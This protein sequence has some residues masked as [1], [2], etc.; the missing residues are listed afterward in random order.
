M[1]SPEIVYGDERTVGYDYFGY[2]CYVNN[3]SSDS[4]LDGKYVAMSGNGGTGYVKVYWK[5]NTWAQRGSTIN[6]IN[7]EEGMGGAVHINDD[8]TKVIAMAKNY[9]YVFNW[10]GTSDWTLSQS[11]G[12][13]TRSNFNDMS[14]SDDGLTICFGET[15][16]SSSRGLVQVWEYDSVTAQYAQKGTNNSLTGSS[17]LD[18]FGRS[19]DISNDGN[20]IV[21]GADGY[22]G[23]SGAAYVYYWDDNDN[24]WIQLGDT[25]EG[26]YSNKRFGSTVQIGSP[27]N[28]NDSTVIAVS[29]PG[30]DAGFVYIWEYVDNEWKDIVT[31]SKD[32]IHSDIESVLY[33]S[34]R[35]GGGKGLSL[36]NDG[37][38][39][40][41]GD[42]YGGILAIA[43]ILYR[44]S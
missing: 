19:V 29:E 18:W 16:Y 20:R 28:T 43:Y 10:D 35:L 41:I 9:V 34:T 30:N 5:D 21:V 38:V 33:S 27:Y 11:I 2:D 12:P 8:G 17:S 26:L 25:F 44:G 24:D 23:R 36:S 40:C 3:N 13:S 32:N 6:G 1:E 39:L 4:N 15:G 22:S 37:K 7:N 14:A 31:F 42:E